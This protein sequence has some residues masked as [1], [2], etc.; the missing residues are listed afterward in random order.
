MFYGFVIFGF[1]CKVNWTFVK[2]W[3]KKIYVYAN[4]T[5]TDVTFSPILKHKEIHGTY[6]G[7]CAIRYIVTRYTIYLLW[8]QG[9]CYRACVRA[10]FLK[11]V[12]ILGSLGMHNWGRTV[13]QLG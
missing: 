7:P 10:R 13:L 6:M 8:H 9:I 11:I 5:L 1:F 12:H 2:I 3:S 4:I